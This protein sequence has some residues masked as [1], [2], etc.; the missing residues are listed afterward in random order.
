MSNYFPKE[1]GQIFKEA[2]DEKIQNAFFP[3]TPNFSEAFAR[4]LKSRTH[5][6]DF[7]INE[8]LIGFITSKAKAII[9]GFQGPVIDRMVEAFS[10]RSDF[11]IV[12]HQFYILILLQQ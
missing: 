1:D 9:S 3:N 2:I 5:E 10:T 8:L 7:I 11:H 4:I 12:D 6:Q